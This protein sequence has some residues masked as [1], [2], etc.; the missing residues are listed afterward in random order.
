MALLLWPLAAL[1]FLLIVAL[2]GGVCLFQHVM[3][4]PCPLCGGTHALLFLVEGEPRQATIAYPLIIPLVALA[5][6]HT[7]VILVELASSQRVL[8]A[9][10]ATRL[11]WWAAVAL[12]VVWMARMVW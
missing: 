2:P 12:V 10:W 8:S 1:G 5:I 11:W 9:R 6:A 7:A 4:T 3:K